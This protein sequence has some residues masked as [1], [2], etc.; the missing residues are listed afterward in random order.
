MFS[1]LLVNEDKFAAFLCLQKKPTWQKD[2]MKYG[3]H[4]EKLIFSYDFHKSKIIF[5]SLAP[6]FIFNFFTDFL[7]KKKYF[8]HLVQRRQRLTDCECYEKNAITYTCMW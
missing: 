1:T 2:E 3:G 4:T 7:K 8:W 5:N 6:D